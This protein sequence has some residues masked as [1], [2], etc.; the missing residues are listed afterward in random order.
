MEE[1]FDSLY[2]SNVTIISNEFLEKFL[3]DVSPEKIKVFLEG[4]KRR[5][6]DF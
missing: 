2:G 4:N 6:Y 1:L 5:L 3:S